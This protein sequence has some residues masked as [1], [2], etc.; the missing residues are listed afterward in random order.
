[1]L[2]VRLCGGLQLE[3]DGELLDVPRSRRGRS[4]LAW[5]ALHPGRHA[6]GRLAGLFWPDVLETSA[7][8]S[9]RAALTE[10]RAALG[11]A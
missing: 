6:R 8:A 3:R 1:M 11:D 5:L 10:L 4:L 7:R 2:T 9:L